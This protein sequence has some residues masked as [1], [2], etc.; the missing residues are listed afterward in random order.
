MYLLKKRD[1]PPKMNRILKT[2]FVKYTNQ[3]EQE[4][5]LEV[6]NRETLDR[7]LLKFYAEFRKWKRAHRLRKDD[8]YS[9]RKTVVTKLKSSEVQNE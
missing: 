4:K 6:C 7:T 5:N 8:Q 2:V 3:G 9:A 1:K